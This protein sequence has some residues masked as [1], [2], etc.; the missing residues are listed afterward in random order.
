[1]DTQSR[2][3]ER[4]GGEGDRLMGYPPANTL[5]VPHTSFMTIHKK[6]IVI[7]YGLDLAIYGFYC[8]LVLP[9]SSRKV[10][11]LLLFLCI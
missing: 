5:F 11:V 10:S 7:F 9:V 1:M 2:Y 8:L 6:V 4:P 3:G